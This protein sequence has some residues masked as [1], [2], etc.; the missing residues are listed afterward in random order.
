[1]KI[2]RANLAG[3]NQPE[4][5]PSPR[6]SK[7]CSL[8]KSFQKNFKWGFSGLLL[9]FGLYNFMHYKLVYNFNIA[10]TGGE[11][12]KATDLAKN[13]FSQL[14]DRSYHDS[15]LAS[16]AH[17]CPY[18]IALKAVALIID[19]KVRAHNYLM[20]FEN[21]FAEDKVQKAFDLIDEHLT[22]FE[23]DQAL[24]CI[25]EGDFSKETALLAHSKISLPSIKEKLAPRIEAIQNNP[26][27]GS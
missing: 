20:L 10:R 14:H 12:I 8:S 22:T 1:M 13:F 11:C 25:I 4:I 17:G 2:Q 24:I 27:N 21:M 5:L 15:A 26:R 19:P 7:C 6:V 18:D 3:F 9:A 23:R 16:V